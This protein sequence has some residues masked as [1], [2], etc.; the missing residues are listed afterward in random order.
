ME[1]AEQSTI[2]LQYSK[3]HRN[4]DDLHYTNAKKPIICY[5]CGGSHKAPD[6]QY[7]GTVFRS[8]G[9]EGH[10]CRSKTKDSKKQQGPQGGPRKPTIWMREIMMM[11]TTCLLVTT[12]QPLALCV[13]GIVKVGTGRAQAIQ[14]VPVPYQ[15]RYSPYIASYC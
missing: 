13:N 12:N 3:Q 11:N 10:V 2:D 14:S 5:L 7:N 9:K 6:C 8:C 4:P 1:T 15:L